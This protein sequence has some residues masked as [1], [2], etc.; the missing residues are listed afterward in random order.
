MVTQ[1]EMRNLIDAARTRG[2]VVRTSHAD[3]GDIRE[4]ELIDVPGVG[5][6]AMPLVQAA[7]RLREFLR[8]VNAKG[9]W[10]VVDYQRDGI[11]GL[12]I[13]RVDADG[14]PVETIVDTTAIDAHP[15]SAVNR[16]FI[17]ACPALL[18]AC[19]LYDEINDYI[20]GCDLEDDTTHPLWHIAEKMQ[21]ACQKAYGTFN[22]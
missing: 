13:H 10:A 17:E 14:R 20:E 11:H 12:W 4:V 15:L 21:V 22:P 18:E 5:P 7:E 8:D 9:D 6:Q 1:E 19:E 16:S 2:A 3:N